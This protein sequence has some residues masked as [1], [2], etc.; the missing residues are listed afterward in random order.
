MR[1][2]NHLKEQTDKEILGNNL[3]YN[4]IYD[5]LVKDSVKNEYIKAIQTGR[6]FYEKV[7]NAMKSVKIRSYN[8]SKPEEWRRY[9]G[10]LLK[11]LN[12]G[13]PNTFTIKNVAAVQKNKVSLAGFGSFSLQS[14]MDKWDYFSAVATKKAGIIDPDNH[15]E[16]LKK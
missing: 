13:I 5:R 11:A 4:Q 14:E 3:K 9:N 2:K 1:F 6:E 12:K 8:L 7:R 15:K 16:W 10:D